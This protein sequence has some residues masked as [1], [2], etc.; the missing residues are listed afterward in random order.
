MFQSLDDCGIRIPFRKVPPR[1]SVDYP[2][3][4]TISEFFNGEN[5]TGYETIFADAS[6]LTEIT[7]YKF[8]HGNRRLVE[9]LINGLR[10]YM[11]AWKECIKHHEK[12][13]GTTC[14]N[15]SF[16][17]MLYSGI[18]EIEDLLQRK[19]LGITDRLDSFEKAVEF[20]EIWNEIQHRMMVTYYANLIAFPNFIKQEKCVWDDELTCAMCTLGDRQIM[21]PTPN[22]LFLSG[23]F[24]PDD[25]V[26]PSRQRVVQGV[27]VHENAGEREIIHEHVHG[28]IHQCRTQEE[29]IL[30]DYLDEGFAEWCAIS[31][32]KPANIPKGIFREKYDFWI[33][34]NSLPREVALRIFD[35]YISASER[36]KW[37]TFVEAA[38]ETIVLYKEQNRRKKFWNP[39]EKLD[40]ECV[41][42]LVQL[43]Q[44]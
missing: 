38:T 40:R 29:Q 19:I 44:I 17:A 4:Q 14:Y 39:E 37:K 41:Q 3:A 1:R 34:I 23:F 12:R 6:L 25:F 43:L 8:V 28:Y 36:I 33:I 18:N 13:E 5:Y 26:L 20:V 10:N 7:A 24:T 16:R 42:R 27:Y 2:F 22:F 21:N 15:P 31:L 35:E 9:Q 30:C 11:V 32:K